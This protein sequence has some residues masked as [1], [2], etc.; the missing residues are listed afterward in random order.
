MVSPKFLD[1]KNVLVVDGHNLLIRILFSK[2]KGNIVISQPELIRECCLIFIHQVIICVKKYSCERAYVA[3]DNGGSIRKK[4]LFEEYKQNRPGAGTNY[5]QVTAFNDSSTDLFAELKA[6]AIDLCKIFNLPVFHEYGIEADDFIAILTNQ[7]NSIGKQVILLSNDSDFLQL[8]KM[9]SVICS[10]PYNKSEVS[11]DNF[12]TYFSSLTKSKGVNISSFE[13]VF[14][15]TIVGDSSDN[16]NGIKGI[17]YKTLHKLMLEQLPLE[18][19]ETIKMYIE[20]SLDY[21]NLLS[22]RNT[23]KI[24]K[25]VHEN[26]DLIIRN[27]KLI[28]LSE[29]YISPSTISLSIK[30]SME[31]SETPDK[32]TVISEFNKL[33][34]NSGM[35]DFVLNALFSFKVIYHD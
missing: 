5:G 21:V 14:Y 7:F 29:R 13:Y 25:L 33:F 16:I 27:Y 8:V 17:G 2:N 4:K 15:K 19:K 10:I 9:P 22:T 26:L 3:F 32:K 1:T 12:T 34:P 28:E 24:E 31:V 6:K 20:N 23:T 18:T 11:I 35:L 30:K